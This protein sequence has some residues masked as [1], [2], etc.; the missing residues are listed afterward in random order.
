[1]RQ[2]DHK[3]VAIKTKFEDHYRI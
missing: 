2:M 3:K 1:M